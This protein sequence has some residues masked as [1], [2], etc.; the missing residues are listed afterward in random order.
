MEIN[1]RESVFR[2]E[3]YTDFRGDVFY[4]FN[5]LRSSFTTGLTVTDSSVYVYV[6]DRADNECTTIRV[7]THE[8]TYF[9]GH[10]F[11]FSDY[12][13]WDDLMDNIMEYLETAD[14]EALDKL[15]YQELDVLVTAYYIGLLDCSLEYY[16]KEGDRTGKPIFSKAYGDAVKSEYL[17]T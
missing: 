16:D 3:S 10:T 2:Y 9:S 1:F 13:D 14:F 7:S 12:I 17:I 4:H 5:R 15:T 6:V 11:I 8:S